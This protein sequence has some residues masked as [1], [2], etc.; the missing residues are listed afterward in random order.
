MASDSSPQ[1]DLY[2]PDCERPACVEVLSEREDLYG[3][4]E[5]LTHCR[6]CG[7]LGHTPTLWKAPPGSEAQ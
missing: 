2:C 5:Y 1:R 7:R 3:K 4:P 6:L